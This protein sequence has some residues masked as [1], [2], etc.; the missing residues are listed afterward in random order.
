MFPFTCTGSVGLPQ[1]Q[2]DPG[3]VAAVR[4][5]SKLHGEFCGSKGES[6]HKKE[7]MVLL[8]LSCRTERAADLLAYHLAFG[9][10]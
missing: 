10:V 4:W 8:G 3:K 5:S 1:F 2:Y 9:F 6:L 7:V